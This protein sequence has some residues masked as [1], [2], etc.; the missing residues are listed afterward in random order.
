[1]QYFYPVGSLYWS[2][3]P[4]DPTHWFDDLE[5]SYTWEW[6]QI[7]D[8]FILAAGTTYPAGSSG[9][10]AEHKLTIY[11][12]PSHLH[13]FGVSTY[14]PALSREDIVSV[15]VENRT[16]STYKVPGTSSTSSWGS[17]TD[18]F[19][20]GGNWPHNNMPPYKAMYCYKRIR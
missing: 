20:A 14:V 18:T 6:E 7:T 12:M 15:Y 13:S 19:R 8:T 10:E 9:G 4:N 3:Q 16:G 11:E 17:M 1:M 5:I 2:E